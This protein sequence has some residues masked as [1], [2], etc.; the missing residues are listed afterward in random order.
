MR[1]Y[2]KRQCVIYKQAWQILSMK[3]KHQYYI[4]SN[5]YICQL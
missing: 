5:I 4:F 1:R 2:L 3:I